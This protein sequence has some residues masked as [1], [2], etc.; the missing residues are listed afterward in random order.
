MTSISTAIFAGGKPEIAHQL[1]GDVDISESAVDSYEDYKLV[2]HKRHDLIHA[3]VCDKLQ[4]P[5]GE[6][7]VD[8]I[9]RDLSVSTESMLYYEEVKNQTPDYFTIKDKIAQ[10]V[11]ITVSHDPRAKN[12][13]A[14][15]YALLCSV[16]KKSRI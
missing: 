8:K 9:L 10:I 1:L 5:F 13:K 14:S 7:S 6:K 12:R 11:E 16:L 3:S 15:K 2:Y 4:I